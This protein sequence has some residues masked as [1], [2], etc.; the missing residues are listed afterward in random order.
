[1]DIAIAVRARQFLAVQ[2]GFVVDR[3]TLDDLRAHTFHGSNLA[4][5][6]LFGNDDN[7]P[8]AE[9]TRGIGNRLPVIAGGGGDNAALALLRTKLGNK[10]DAAAH[11]EG[12][13]RLVVLVFYKKRC[14]D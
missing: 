7:G 12:P 11:L 3:A 8:D 6:G 9:E 14:P 5:I 2:L 10:I 1:M 4:R 13:Y